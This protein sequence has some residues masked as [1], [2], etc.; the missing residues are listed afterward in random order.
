MPAAD[1]HFTAEE[2][3]ARLTATREAM[4]AEGL[5][6]LVVTDP[7][8]MHW[9]TGYDGWSFYV[10]QAVVV[11]PD[12]PPLWW[13][14]PQD[15]AGAAQTVWMPDAALLDYPEALV[16]NPPAHPHA[17]LADH[18]KGRGL[19]RARI[20]VEM[21][22]YYY[23]A[24][25]HA[26]LQA[27][28]PDARLADATGLVN[29]RRA[30]KSPAELALMRQA[31]QIVDAMHA[32][33]ATSLRP[34][35]RK[36]D[37]VAAVSAAGVR[38]TPEAGG[39]Y[40]A[41]VPIAPSG[42]EASAAH[43]TWNDAPLRPGEAT[44]FEIAGCRRRYHCPLSRTYHL[45]PPPDAMRRGEEAVLEALDAALAA[46]R[47]GAPCE[48]VAQTVY[49]AFHRRGFH[50][51]SRTGYP[52]GLSYPPDWGERTMSLRP[53]DRTAMRENMTFHL[54]PGLW[55][56]DWGVAITETFVVT[57][58]GGRPLAS[59]PREIAVL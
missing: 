50:K 32:E 11:P 30:I 36:C 9:L 19:G 40:P 41:I 23:S 39:D 27:G 2:Y 28:L 52:V 51:D 42:V 47:P 21:D 12:G 13:G 38:G 58:H 3:A 24:A 14:R 46:A 6:A 44:Y 37:V 54:M 35:V 10:H 56:P 55:T 18:L 8:N 25:A 15:R 4:A 5:D 57:P 7:S 45:G 17:V 34:G 1:P 31:A 29:W 43:L 26:A 49:D 20:G 59:R 16:Q 53:G 22:N 48:V 33:I